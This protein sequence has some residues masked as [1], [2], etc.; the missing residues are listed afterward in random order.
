MML[1]DGKAKLSFAARKLAI[2]WDDATAQW[3]DAVSRDFA[4]RH[5]AP[6]EPKVG[7]ALRAIERLAELLQR[8][9][10]ECR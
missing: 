3:N 4:E 8:A 1:F 5:L 7:G 6:L 10:Q 9:E 2:R